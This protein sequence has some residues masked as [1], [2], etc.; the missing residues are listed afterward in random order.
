MPTRRYIVTLASDMDKIE[1]P[2]YVAEQLPN[3][4]RFR[5]GDFDQAYPVEK[6]RFIR[7]VGGQQ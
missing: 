1:P 3:D 5:V 7:E 2:E 4:S 6:L